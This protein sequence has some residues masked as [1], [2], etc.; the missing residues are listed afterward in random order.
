MAS[1]ASN[2]GTVFCML[3]STVIAKAD[4][5]L[6]LSVLDG[7]FFFEMERG[8]VSGFNLIMH[9]FLFIFKN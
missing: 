6:L 1:C 3:S 4:L 5:P 9:S 8:G 2:A 7:F